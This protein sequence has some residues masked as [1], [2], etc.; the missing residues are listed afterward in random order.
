MQIQAGMAR[1]VVRVAVACAVGVAGVGLWAGF[2]PAA[3]ADPGGVF[4]CVKNASS[5]PVGIAWDIRNG[6]KDPGGRYLAP[7]SR[8][9]AESTP[10][11]R[12]LMRP[13]K[14]VTGSTLVWRV[15]ARGR[16]VKVDEWL[17]TSMLYEEWRIDRAKWNDIGVGDTRRV[18]VPPPGELPGGDWQ[19]TLQ[20][21]PNDEH[22][23][24][25][26]DT[27]GNR[28]IRYLLTIK[29]S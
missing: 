4:L 25:G 29:E 14:E 17:N 18:T 21:F 24:G 9:C 2:A 22:V 15:D 19:F 28:W 20:R 7:G 13:G 27:S 16:D 11:L 8:R 1:R 5:K 6:S 26:K 12:L 10:W 23:G 3:A